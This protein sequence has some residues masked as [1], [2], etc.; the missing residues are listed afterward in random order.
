MGSTEGA[1]FIDS[2]QKET[3]VVPDPETGKPETVEDPDISINNHYALSVQTYNKVGPKNEVYLSPGQAVAFRL[4]MHSSAV[5]VSLDI[6]AK[7]INGTATK[8][9]AGI[10]TASADMES[11]LTVETATRKDLTTATAMYYPLAIT[12]SMISKDHYCYIVIMNGMDGTDPRNGDHVLSITDIKVCYSNVLTQ[13]LPE[14]GSGDPEIHKRTVTE[15]EPISFLVDRNTAE[16]AA[17]FLRKEMETPILDSDTKIYHSL[18]LAS[19]ISLNYVVAKS[20]LEGADSFYMQC[21]V[22]LYEGNL[23]AGSKTLILQPVEKSGLYYFTLDGIT[24]IQMNDVIRATLYMTK[25]GQAFCSETDSYS[26]AQY[27]YTQLNKTGITESL[28]T[29]CADL[30]RYGSKAQIFKAY[31]TDSLADANMTEEHRACLSDIEAVTFGN[32]NRVLDDLTNAPITWAGKSLNLESKVAL[33][34]VFNP[35]AYK[36]DLTALTLR[37]SHTDTQGAT[38]T[39]TVSNPELYNES[40]GYYVFTV[41]SLLA[42]ELRAVVSAQIYNGDTP[43]SATLQYSP[44]TY[45]NNKTGVLEDLCKALFAYS[46]SAK[47]YFQ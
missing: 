17:F 2:Y 24:A 9:V 12:D 1:V 29:L 25:D 20:D 15:E 3:V 4:K 45:G 31:R 46:D 30:L 21:E 22:P 19:D 26:I 35:A 33:K 7:T 34:F 47:A 5:P 10:V 13:Q 6:G 18:N 38:K 40:L 43:V 39:A 42:A 23:R 16:A 27:A 8:L 32:T 37:I 41:D 14:D 28:K 44:D 11:V 36:G